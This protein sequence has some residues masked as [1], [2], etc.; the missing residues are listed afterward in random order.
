MRTLT[1]RTLTMRTLTACVL[2]PLA[3]TAAAQT[4]A[5]HVVQGD[6]AYARLDPPAA[7]AHYEAALA[8]D[9][10][11]YDALWKAARSVVDIGKQMDDKQKKVR[12]SL[13]A[14]ADHYA[15]AAV[16]ANPEGADGYFMLGYAV[17][18]LALTRGSK[19]R[20]AY[21]TEI[22]EAAVTALELD[23]L[24]DG[25][26]H[27]LG[28]WHAEIMRLPGITKFFA[29]T[30]LGARVFNEASWDNAVR[31]LERAVEINPTNV[32]HHLD[33]KQPER[34]RPHLEQL[35]ELPNSDVM[36]PTYKE[37]ARAHLA[38]RTGS[39]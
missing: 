1:M 32:Y 2:L 38:Q 35:L 11:N 20:V 4:V 8:L 18:Q 16:E 27:V 5:E 21:A 30:F 25:A 24:H 26:H 19:E 14:V 6:E 31:H 12:D 37:E 33:L 29:K 17:G 10:T 34:A 23:S 9:S 36:D 39:G 3:T 7:L 13:Y 22:R 15:R 28:R